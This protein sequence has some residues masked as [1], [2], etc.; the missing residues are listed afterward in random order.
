MRQKQTAQKDTAQEFTA[1]KNT[2]RK[3][4][5][6]IQLNRVQ[7]DLLD[8][9]FMEEKVWYPDYYGFYVAAVICLA[10]AMLLFIMPYQLWESDYFAVTWGLFL[11]TM[12]LEMYSRRYL[13]YREK[14]KIKS[15]RTVLQ[16]LPVSGEQTALYIFR[17][18]MKLCLCLTGG[19]AACQILFSLILLHRICWGNILMPVICCLIIPVLFPGVTIWRRVQP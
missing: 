12:G 3:K 17:K 18:L 7:Q 2:E 4:A 10:I 13:Q 1:Q 11:E 15:I 6:P 19:A 14:E 8:R 16:Y 9:F 5:G